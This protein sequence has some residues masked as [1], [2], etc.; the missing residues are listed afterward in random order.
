[1]VT[2]GEVQAQLVYWRQIFGGPFVDEAFNCIELRD[3]NYM[4]AGNKEIQVPGQ[5]YQI[6]KSYIV[7]FDRIGNILWEKLIG[8]STKLN[9]SITLTEDPDGNIYLPFSDYYAHLL[10]MNSDGEILWHKE[11]SNS[12]IQLFRGISFENNFKNIVLLGQSLIE[13]FYWTSSLTKL[14]SSGNLIWTKPYYDSIPTNSY[15]TSHNNSFMFN[16]DSYYISGSKGINGFII[17]TDTSGNIIWNRRY[18]DV[19]GLYSFAELSINNFIISGTTNF[20]DLVCMK[21]DNSGNILWKKNYINDTLANSIGSDKII[22][23]FQNNFV[24]GHYYGDEFA[25][26]LTVDSSG[27]IIS[28]NSYAY[29]VNK[30]ISQYNINNTS[31]SGYIVSG[32]IRK[33]NNNKILS[34]ENRGDKD[35]DILVYKIDKEGQTVSINS[36]QS[37]LID[38]FDIQIFS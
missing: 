14:D 38:N 34:N 12:N 25:K 30:S 31:D 16:D 10:K 24:L 17:K 19:I 36:N 18:F 6:P 5:I 2:T 7:K 28:A 21:I 32:A 3:G 33:W 37:N 11:Y 8:D 22:K 27:N 23:N 15:Y 26:I 20:G 9:R 1:M 4:M 13:N 35:I 29:P